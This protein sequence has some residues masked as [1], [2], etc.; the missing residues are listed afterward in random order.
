MLYSK[1]LKKFNLCLILSL[2]SIQAPVN[3]QTIFEGKISSFQK[4]LEEVKKNHKNN[5]RSLYAQKELQ[6]KD[7]YSEEINDIENLVE[8]LF[9]SKIKVKSNAAIDTQ[10]NDEFEE[11]INRNF[12]DNK[13]NKRIKTT[14]KLEKNNEKFI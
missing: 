1:Y 2:I 6:E 4:K 12:E 9:D 7:N 10:M 8:E 5:D 3:S 11:S 14:I 13:N